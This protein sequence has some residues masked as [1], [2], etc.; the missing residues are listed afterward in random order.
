MPNK[1]QIWWQ[2]VF[3]CKWRGGPYLIILDVVW[4]TGNNSQVSPHGGAK[5]AYIIYIH[6]SQTVF[7]KA[8]VSTF[9]T[10][11][12]LYHSQNHRRKTLH[13]LYHCVIYIY[14]YTCFYLCKLICSIWISL[15]YSR[16]VPPIQLSLG[17]AVDVSC[18]GGI[19]SQSRRQRRQ[20]RRAGSTSMLRR[21]LKGTSTGNHGLRMDLHPHI[22]VS[23]SFSPK[24]SQLRKEIHLSVILTIYM[25]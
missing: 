4:H 11:I 20:R 18:G 25:I 6:T 23:D 5:V 7:K 16:W 2:L 17:D 3:C 8:N 19:A 14:I 24:P 15:R 12:S 1:Y 13:M 22:G 21:W 10:P 9:F